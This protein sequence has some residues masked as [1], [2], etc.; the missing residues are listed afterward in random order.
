[1]IDDSKIAT[2]DQPVGRNRS[3]YITR[4]GLSDDGLLGHW[5]QMQARTEDSEPASAPEEG[6]P[7]PNGQAR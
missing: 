1:M 5:E 6:V 3:N 2:H 4:L 7:V